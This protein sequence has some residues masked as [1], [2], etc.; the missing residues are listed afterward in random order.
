M[1]CEGQCLKWRRIRGIGRLHW[2]SQLWGTWTSAPRLPTTNFFSSFQ[3]YT[4]ST[5]VF[6]T[7]LAIQER[8]FVLVL[9][10]IVFVYPSRPTNGTSLS[11]S[12]HYYPLQAFRV[13][14][15]APS[16]SES[17]RFVSCSLRTKSWRRR[18]SLQLSDLFSMMHL[19]WR[20][21]RPTALSDN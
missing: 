2:R 8:C 20:A 14:A 1:H 10:E 7:W 15:S 3:S 16:A 19:S 18:W 6:T 9:L 21:R 5:I 12:P 13:S 17:R 4:K 11:G